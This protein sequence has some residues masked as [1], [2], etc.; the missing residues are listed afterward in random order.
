MMARYRVTYNVFNFHSAIR[1]ESKAQIIVEVEVKRGEELKHVAYLHASELLPEMKFMIG[2][3][4]A[5][6][7]PVSVERLRPKKV[8]RCKCGAVMPDD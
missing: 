8:R 5:M 2:G 3:D 6:G 4:K 1:L 7:P